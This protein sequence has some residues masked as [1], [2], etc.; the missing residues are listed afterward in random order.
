MSTSKT[1][2]TTNLWFGNVHFYK[3][4]LDGTTDNLCIYLCHTNL[5][6]RV[7]IV[8]M[9][10][11]DENKYYIT[12]S[13][14]NKV[15]YPLDAFEIN[16]EL[17]GKQLSLKGKRIT[18]SY[19][20]Y[21]NISE[22]VIS[23]LC[24]KIFNT[25]HQLGSIRRMNIQNI[26]YSITEDYYKY[27]TWFEHKTNIQ[28]HKSIK[29]NPGLIKWGLYYIE[30]GENV[31]SELHKL[32]PAIIFRKNIS[33]KNPSDSSYIVIPITS[34]TRA[35]RYYFNVPITVNGD[36]NYAKLND[37]RRISVKRVVRPLYDKNGKTIVLNAAEKQSIKNNL[38]LYLFG[39]NEYFF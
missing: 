35:S 17:I 33:N 31:G 22:S 9:N 36:V 5:A 7:C 20:E 16:E 23:K 38:K 4:P 18:I 1:S 24:N 15:A 12:I 26:D 25:Y 27:I 3:N 21:L 10:E 2:A 13:G 28:F 32:R 37:I 39:E 6:K 30:I 11:I 14:M 19:E 29:R 34:K 8:P